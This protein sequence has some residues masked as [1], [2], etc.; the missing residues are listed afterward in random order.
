[1]LHFA[2]PETSTSPDPMMLTS[3]VPL[4]WACTPPDPAM[5]TLSCCVWMAP[6][7][8]PPEPAISYSADWALPDPLTSPEP[9]IENLSCCTS[10][11]PT[12]IPPEPA[13]VPSNRWPCTRSTR[14]SPDPAI[15]APLRCGN[16][17]VK[18]ALTRSCPQQLKTQ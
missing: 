14:I 5:E 9:P 12:L 13:T 3:A 15:V 7:S 6:A 18:F 16:V 11:A 1:M 10:I 2:P 17:K 4:E 8:T